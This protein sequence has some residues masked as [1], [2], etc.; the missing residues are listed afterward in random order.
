MEVPRP[1]Y[2][3]FPRLFI[4][5]HPEVL[6]MTLNDAYIQFKIWFRYHCRP[7][8]PMTCK[9]VFREYYNKLQV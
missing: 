8:Y 4:D 9:H 3:E 2:S 1:P 5:N 6:D 7:F